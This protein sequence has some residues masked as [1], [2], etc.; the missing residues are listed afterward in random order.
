[1]AIGGSPIGLS[2]PL[3]VE[4]T[5]ALQVRLSEPSPLRM[6]RTLSEPSPLRMTRTLAF[7]VQAS[8]TVFVTSD[9]MPYCFVQ[10]FGLLFGSSV[11]MPSFFV[12]A[13]GLLYASSVVMP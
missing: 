8:G 2:E 6:T 10:A 4:S 9:V 1:M 11:D 7:F 5:R 3:I 12:Q 13:F